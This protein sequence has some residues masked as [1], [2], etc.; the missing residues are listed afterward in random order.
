[1]S[2]NSQQHT[3]LITAVEED[4]FELFKSINDGLKNQSFDLDSRTPEKRNKYDTADLYQTISV[5]L[6]YIKQL[7]SA[8]LIDADKSTDIFPTTDNNLELSTV[9]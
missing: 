4:I 7:I 3:Q 2:T 9:L 1:M 8:H 6:D 5:M